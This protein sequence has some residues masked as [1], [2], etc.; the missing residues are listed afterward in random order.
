MTNKFQQNLHCTIEGDRGVG[1]TEF[2]KKISKVL[3][4]YGKTKTENPISISMQNLAARTTYGITARPPYE[5]I[6]SYS[7]VR[8][9][10][11]EEGKLY[12]LTGIK[13]FVDDYKLYKDATIGIGEY[14]EIK[15]KQYPTL[16]YQK[17]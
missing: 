14:K 17:K 2:I 13:E 5:P 9:I 3:Y 11:I 7:E 15:R 1:K 6:N 8:R 16:Q 12:V 10:D 4:R